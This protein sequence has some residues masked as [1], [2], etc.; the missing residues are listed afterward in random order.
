M[1]KRI[2]CFGFLLFVGMHVSG[3]RVEYGWEFQGIADNR[4]FF[5]GYSL[6]ETLLGSRLSVDAGPSIDTIHSVRAGF[7]Y[8]YAFG[9]PA[10]ETKPAPLLYYSF[11]SEKWN[12]LMGAFPRNR[13][14]PFPSALISEK[15]TYY[16]STLEGLSLLYASS[17]FSF[18]LWVDWQSRIDSLHREQFLAG[19]AASAHWGDLRLEG[20]ALLF[21]DRPNFQRLPGDFINDYLGG[22]FL[23]AYDF[24]SHVPID[25]FRIKAGALASLFRNRGKGSAFEPAAAFYA[26]IELENKGF[27]ITSR[28]K[29]GAPLTFSHGDPFY[30]NTRTYWRTDLYLL[31]FRHK[32]ISGKLAWCFHLADGKLDHSQQ[33]ILTYTFQPI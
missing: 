3:Q 1:K 8:Y 15:E 25:L 13:T 24:S 7:S 16:Q 27:G 31:P 26:V 20:H 22:C 2:F 29:T 5:S 4:E 19:W 10:L 18:N 14:L 32:K 6:P 9:A 28:F 11:R 23:T 21:H 33:F 12:F 30:R 17:R